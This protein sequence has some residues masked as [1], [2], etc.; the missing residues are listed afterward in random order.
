[1]D[2]IE[3]IFYIIQ[4]GIEVGLIWS[5]L[6]LGVFIS[7]RVLDT[8]DL[9]A[10]GAV[11]LGSAISV[12]LILKGL[13]G[14]LALVISLLGGFAA[15]AI[16]GVLHT[17]LK[18]PAILSGIITMTG[19]YS[20]NLRIMGGASLPLGD[21]DNVYTILGSIINNTSYAKIITTLFIVI[22]VFFLLYW[23]FGTEIG[24]SLRATGMNQKMARAQG[25]NTD[26]MII[27]G[28]AIANGLI[29][30]SGGLS[31]QSNRTSSMDVGRGTIVIGLA[32]IIIGEVLFGKRSFKNWL[33]SVI[34]GSVIFQIIVGIAI[35]VGLNPLD[36]KLVQA[37]LI[38]VILAL[39][40]IKKNIK[41][42][43]K[44]GVRVDATYK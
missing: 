18:I 16:T 44:K 11:T 17:K 13:G 36:L 25:V 35:T 42:I 31:A 20:I 33:I 21:M 7:F 2:V 8:A 32:S 5:L 14:P 15:G 41:N 19:L 4:D 3:A 10:E 26:I 9:T 39:P 29:A 38:G 40:V 1:M 27:L 43:K 22:I 37:I 23:F 28:L 6:G 30:L 24:M 34:L 12:S